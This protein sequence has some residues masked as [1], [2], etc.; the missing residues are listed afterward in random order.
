MSLSLS[1]FVLPFP[2]LAVHALL[3]ITLP[4]G[5]ATFTGRLGAI[6]N[7]WHFP[8][9]VGSGKVGV[10]GVTGVIGPGV[11]GAVKL[12]S[13]EGVAGVSGIDRHAGD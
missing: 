5:N 13:V 3:F 11:D 9:T 1:S 6:G 4:R 10:V 7:N 8:F 2:L 12:A